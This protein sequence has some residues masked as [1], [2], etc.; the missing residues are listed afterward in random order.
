MRLAAPAILSL[1]LSLAAGC[2][3]AH[4]PTAASLSDGSA[5]AT[6]AT[7]PSP[8]DAAATVSAGAPFRFVVWG[9]TKV[10]TGTSAGAVLQGLSHDVQALSPA[11]AFTVYLG[12]LEETGFSNAAA[13]ADEWLARLDGGAANGTSRVT[14]ATRGNHDAIDPA[15]T[16]EWQSYF[17]FAAVAR[18]V[19]ATHY[20]ELTHQLTYSFDYGNAHLVSLDVPGDFPATATADEL[21]WLEQDLGAAEARGLTHA[22]LFW[23]G[24]IYSVG[25]VHPLDNG[26]PDPA[27]QQLIAIA[28][29][30]PIVSAVLAGH[31]HLLAYEHIGPRAFPSLTIPHEFEQFTVGT[32]GAAFHDP[33]PGRGDAVLPYVP[34]FATVDVEGPSFTVTWRPQGSGSPQGTFTFHK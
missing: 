30:H 6:A 23:H 18:Q 24:P 2:T 29:R 16:A 34:A 5:G 20:T 21:A 4:A 7:T 10:D 33:V 13:L 15:S 26:N 28:A 17:D 22:F 31:E 3:S 27:I 12:D 1:C 25:T 19:G 9:D 11:P 14:F 32:G 8:A